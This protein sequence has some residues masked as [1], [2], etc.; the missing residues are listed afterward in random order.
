LSSEIPAA[1][2]RSKTMIET[3]SYIYGLAGRDFRVEDVKDV[4]GD[5]RALVE[6]GKEIEQF[7]YIG[8]RV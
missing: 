6:E 4:F 8:L 2:F 1:L 5:L 3:V 7:R